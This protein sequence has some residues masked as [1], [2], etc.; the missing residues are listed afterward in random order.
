MAD[1]ICSDCSYRACTVV[2]KET[3]TLREKRRR[4]KRRRKN[5]GRWALS[6]LWAACCSF[7][8][9]TSVSLMHTPRVVACPYV[10]HPRPPQSIGVCNNTTR[11]HPSLYITYLT[12]LVK[13]TDNSTESCEV[14]AIIIQLTQL[15]NVQYEVLRVRAWEWQCEVW[16]RE[17]EGD[18]VKAT[19]W[20]W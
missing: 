15:W 16:R 2:R 10:R 17:C 11:P 20:K 3:N 1:L 5:N 13:L 19:V 14:T 9:C 4:R 7:E 6:I 18:C 12:W 8:W